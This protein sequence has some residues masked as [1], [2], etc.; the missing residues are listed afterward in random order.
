MAYLWF[1][2]SNSSSKALFDNIPLL[3]V[4][5]LGSDINRISLTNHTG[6]LYYSLLIKMVG[7]KVN[8]S[9]CKDLSVKDETMQVAK[10]SF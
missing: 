3:V 6:R 1:I 8:F 7:I 4:R 2:T 9:G 10:M 5:F